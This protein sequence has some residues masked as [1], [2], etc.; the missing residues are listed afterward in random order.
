[1]SS[2]NVTNGY[3]NFRFANCE[4]LAEFTKEV[5][6]SQANGF[7]SCT[8]RVL[9]LYKTYTT[10]CHTTYIGTSCELQQAQVEQAQAEHQSI[11]ASAMPTVSRGFLQL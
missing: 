5:T 4:V 7:Y 2:E 3:G 9:V 6:E 10:D 1:M 11:L 8:L